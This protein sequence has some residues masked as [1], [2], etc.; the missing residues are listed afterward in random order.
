MSRNIKVT[1]LMP[2]GPEDQMDVSLSSPHVVRQRIA[3]YVALPRPTFLFSSP[4]EDWGIKGMTN[5]AP[6]HSSSLLSPLS[7]P[8]HCLLCHLPPSH[9][10]GDGAAGP[11]RSRVTAGGGPHLSS[12]LLTTMAAGCVRWLSVATD[13]C[14]FLSA[15]KRRI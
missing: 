12:L 1:G 5:D 2:L 14:L 7:P 6:L 4:G 13:G 15:L 8:S 10:R 11:R 9:V 3:A